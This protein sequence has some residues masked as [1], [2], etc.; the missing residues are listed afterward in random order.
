MNTAKTN[1]NNLKIAISISEFAG[2]YLQKRPR[3]IFKVS[4]LPNKDLKSSADKIVEEIILSK[5][6]KTST[7][8]I[9]SEESGHHGEIYDNGP[10]WIVD[11]LDGTMNFTRNFPMACISIAL[12]QNNEPILGIV[13]DFNRKKM[14]SALVGEDVKLNDENISVT[15]TDTVQQA[16][17]ATGFPIKRNYDSGSLEKFISQVQRFKK[18]RMIGAAALSLAYVALGVFD[19]YYEED[20]MIWDVAAGLALVKAA[21]GE[22]YIK[23]GSKKHSVVCAATN[24][25]IS[26]KELIS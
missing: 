4:L 10:Y 22:I 25:K 23:P 2:K 8:P 16:V 20:I 1:K 21:G 12:W 18:I 9:L 26:I 5:L 13:Y 15:K 7:Y 6:V 24:G 11:P 19:A 14:Y 3:N 17:L